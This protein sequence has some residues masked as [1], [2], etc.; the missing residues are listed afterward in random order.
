MKEILLHPLMLL[1]VKVMRIGSGYKIFYINK[2][3]QIRGN[4]IYAFNH[5]CH[6]D[7]PIACEI[8][9]KHCYLIVGIQRLKALDKLFFWMNG[10]IWIDRHD[11][12]SRQ[13]G[14]KQIVELLKA[15]KKYSLF[16][17]RNVESSSCKIVFTIV[18]GWNQNCKGS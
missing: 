13:K 7:G 6:M 3:P 14:F 17:R 1:V 2:K 15:G 9:K 12:T 5:S 16:S 11:K 18:L 10:T 4:A 8:I